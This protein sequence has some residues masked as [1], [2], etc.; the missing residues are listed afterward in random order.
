[1]EDALNEWLPSQEVFDDLFAVKEKGSSTENRQDEIKL[2]V[3]AKCIA[4]KGQYHLFLV[5]L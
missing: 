4:L 5:L 3:I 2:E 1:M